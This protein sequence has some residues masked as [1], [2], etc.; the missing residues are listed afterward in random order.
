MDT[1]HQ[2]H[3]LEGDDARLDAIFQAYRTACPDVEAG[4]DFMPRLWQKIE[5]RQ[6]IPTVFGRLARNLATAALALSMLLGLAVSISGS[7]GTQLPSESYVE[8]LAEEHNSSS[9]DFEPVR[10][11]PAA[12]Q[13]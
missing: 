3:H 4:A 6:G 5:S 7:R 8:V 2:N 10:L 12:E 1:D 9:L 11:S 13:R